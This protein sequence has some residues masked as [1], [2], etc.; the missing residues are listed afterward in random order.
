MNA[1]AASAFTLW[2]SSIGK[3]T[4][5]AATGLFFIVFLMAHLGGNLLLFVGQDAFNAYA[6]KLH[7]LGEGSV[8]WIARFVLLAAITLHVVATIQLTKAN[9]AARTAYAH[10]GTLRATKSSKIMIWSGL[11]VLAFIIY[12]ILHFTT[13]TSSAT[14]A[15]IVNTPDPNGYKNAYGMVIEGFRN[16]PTSIFYVIAITLLCSHL[17]HGFA[18]AFQTLG[19]RSKK[20]SDL[21]NNLGK[22]YSVGIWLGFVS[23][24]ISILIFGYGK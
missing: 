16:I 14:L 18:S 17:S 3:K 1:I 19:L 2:N 15:K 7:H 9:R 8:I 21:L 4:V 22:V 20:T 6:H 24:P 13:R 11:T 12:H 23:I 10:E 5:V